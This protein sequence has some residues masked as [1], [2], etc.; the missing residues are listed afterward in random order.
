MT[1]ASPKISPIV[2]VMIAC[3]ESQTIPLR[4]VRVYF[5]PFLRKVLVSFEMEEEASVGINIFD[6]SGWP[7][8]SIEYVALPAGETCIDFDT[9]GLKESLYRIEVFSG[10]FTS[11]HLLRINEIV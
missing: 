7:V 11:S 9:R 8:R 5:N 6:L 10:E 3:T 4:A 2:L 1:A